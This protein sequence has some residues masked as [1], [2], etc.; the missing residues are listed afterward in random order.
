MKIR[1]AQDSEGRGGDVRDVIFSREKP[2]WEIGFSAKNNNDSQKHSRLGNSNDFAKK[3]LGIESSE[4]YW[5]AIAPIF[6]YV[7]DFVNDK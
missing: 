2:H 7:K 3:W 6:E 1:L 5:E 4:E